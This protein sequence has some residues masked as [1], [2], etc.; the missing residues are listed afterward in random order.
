MLI[1]SISIYGLVACSCID[2]KRIVAYSTA[3][4]VVVLCL[5]SLIRYVLSMYTICSNTLKRRREC[6]AYR[7]DGIH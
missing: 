4:N 6:Y 3:W 5:L 2:A 7:E 1:A